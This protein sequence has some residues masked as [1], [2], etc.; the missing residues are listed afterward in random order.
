MDIER[1]EL[2]LLCYLITARP[3]MSAGGANFVRCS[4][5]PSCLFALLDR[6]YAVGVKDASSSLPA[7]CAA[8]EEW[9]SAHRRGERE[10]GA[11]LLETT[12]VVRFPACAR[13]RM[14]SRPMPKRP[15]RPIYGHLLQQTCPMLGPGESVVKRVCSL[16]FASDNAVTEN[17]TPNKGLDYP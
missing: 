5:Q 15:F 16:R 7:R 4:R 9:K 12:A 17:D 10:A 11:H 3:Y 2:V 1:A 13:H 8:L 14:N 6:I